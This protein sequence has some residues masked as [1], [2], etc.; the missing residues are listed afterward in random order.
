MLKTIRFAREFVMRAEL[1]RL[2]ERVIRRCQ[3]ILGE[4][5]RCGSFE[6]GGVEKSGFGIL[7]VALLDGTVVP[8]AMST[9]WTWRKTASENLGRAKN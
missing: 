8:H 4:R 6:G 7:K 1:M 2:S 9:E 5:S 3:S